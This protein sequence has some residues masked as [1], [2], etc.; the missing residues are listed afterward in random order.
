MESGAVGRGEGGVIVGR[1]GGEAGGAF[2][3]FEAAGMGGLGDG[4][5]VVGWGEVTC[6]SRRWWR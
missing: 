3:L 6:Q 2:G 1:E 5:W 4:V